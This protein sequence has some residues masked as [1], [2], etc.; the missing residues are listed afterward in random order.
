[1]TCATQIR[2]LQIA[3]VVLAFVPIGAGFAG[4]VYGI[5]VFE[6][7][8]LL[9]QDAE[10]TGRYLSGLL[11]AIGLAFWA[12]VPRIEAQG[13]R[14]RLLALLV[15]TGGL[16]RLAGLLLVGIPSPVMLGGLAMELLVTPGLALWRER[17][18]PAMQR[19]RHHRPEDGCASRSLCSRL[20]TTESTVGRRR[21]AQEHVRW[22]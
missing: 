13:V 9:G 17:L 21:L 6:P 3:V 15:F 5:G 18:E 7:T 11:F 19:R 4:A 22:T 20:V 12:T 16:A 14:F 2:A 10:S 1:M 8:A